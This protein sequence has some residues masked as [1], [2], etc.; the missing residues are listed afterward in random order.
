MAF[1]LPV[2]IG[3]LGFPKPRVRAEERC[4]TFKNYPASLELSL[5]TLTWPIIYAIKFVP[6]YSTIL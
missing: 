2:S 4:Q 3:T 6:D 5:T 1:R